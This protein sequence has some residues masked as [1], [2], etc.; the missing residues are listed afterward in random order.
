MGRDIH[1]HVLARIVI[2]ELILSH[3]YH[4][5]SS[6]TS[7]PGSMIHFASTLNGIF[8][9]TCSRGMSPVARWQMQNLSHTVD[10]LIRHTPFVDAKGYA[11]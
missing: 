9:M 5:I 6:E 10:S 8:F 4:D 7:L 3:A 1:A 2:L 11:F